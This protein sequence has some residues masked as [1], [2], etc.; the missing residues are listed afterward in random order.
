MMMVILMM[1]TIVIVVMITII[2][3]MIV[4]IIAVILSYTIVIV[5]SNVAT[6]VR[7]KMVGWAHLIRSEGWII[8]SSRCVRNA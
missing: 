4:T 5:G 2:V 3:M 6:K 7:N 8:K 1:V